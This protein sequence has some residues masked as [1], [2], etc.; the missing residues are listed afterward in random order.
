MQYLG[1]PRIAR[2][3]TADDQLQ[4]KFA[5][6]ASA[7]AERLLAAARR[8]LRNDSDAQDALQDG[9]MSAWKALGDFDGRSQLS[10]W[11]HRIVMN[12]ALMQLRR[13]HRQHEVGG[14]TALEQFSGIPPRR[15]PE[16]E[17]CDLLGAGE[18]TDRIMATIESL[19]ASYRGVIQLRLVDE[20]G[21]R[22]TGRLLGMSEA[23]VKVRL[24][25]GLKRLRAKLAS[26][27]A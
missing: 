9:L 10:T 15:N 13:A 22:E 5:R 20:L 24:H 6:V 12:A 7:D 16:M 23:A 2:N 26:K 14:G 27:A 17:P 1:Y 8:I 21:T 25:R 19:P 11:L 3:S 4:A 18:E